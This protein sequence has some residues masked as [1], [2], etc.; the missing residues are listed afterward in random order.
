MIRPAILAA[1][2]PLLYTGQDPSQFVNAPPPGVRFRMNLA[3]ATSA[4]WIDSN[5]WRYRRQTGRQFFSDVRQ[6][7]VLLAMAEAFSQG[8]QVHLQ[9]TPAQ[10]RDYEAMLAFLKTVPE[11]PKTKWADIAVTDDGSAPAGEVLNLLSRRNL[12]FRIAA[13][14]EPGAI[15]L[16][17][18]IR[19]PYEFVQQ[20][21]EK[22]GDEKRLL[23]L[24]GSELTIAELASEGGRVRLHLVHYGTR[25]LESARVRIKG[26]YQADHAQAYIF[27]AARPRLSGFVHEGGYTEFT[28][29]LVPVYAV[30]DL[31]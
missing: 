23:R 25:P 17:S 22:I 27:G 31:R 14:P 15:A 10:K 9:T 21:R 3:M 2:Y 18:A 1:V 8:A 30:I 11:G 6:K 5:I 29:A 24:Y 4:P 13:K 12:L 7:S 20:I 26:D 16:T 28:V 19:N